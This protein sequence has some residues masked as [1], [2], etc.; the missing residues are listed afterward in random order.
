MATTY[1]QIGSTVTVGA[2]GA[3]DITF[4]SIPATYTDLVVKLS[5]RSSNAG[6]SYQ[7]I[8]ISFNGTSTNEL[9]YYL[10]G[11]GSAAA[12]GSTPTFMFLINALPDSGTTASTFGSVDFY[13]PNYASSNNKSSSVDAVTENNGTTAGIGMTA[14]LWSNTAAITSIALTPQAGTFVQYSTASLYGIK[15]T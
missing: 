9:A 10:A 3:A 1:V 12:S 11:T 14:N 2:G 5:T 4:S 7:S 8:G 15:S 6:A 13:I